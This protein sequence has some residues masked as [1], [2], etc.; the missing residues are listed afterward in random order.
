[1]HQYSDDLYR[2]AYFKTGDSHVSEDLVQEVFLGALQ[3]L[4]NSKPVKN[5]KSWLFTILRNKIADYYR[6]IQKSRKHEVGT[7]PEEDLDSA[8][9]FNEMGMWRKGEKPSAWDNNNN[10]SADEEFCQV[11]AACIAKLPEHYQAA[12]E[13]KIVHNV[14]SD[15]I[16]E[17]LEISETNLW[18]IVHRTKLRLRKCINKHWFQ[19]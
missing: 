14:S 8:Q 10:L 17:D 11:L 4:N 12:V 7:F 1:V 9:Y 16:C 2:F 18:Q 13:L 5:Q 3:S 15:L 19:A 6:G